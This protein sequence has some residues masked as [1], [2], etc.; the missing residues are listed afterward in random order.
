MKGVEELQQ[1]EVFR[2]MK[3]RLEEMAEKGELQGVD[4]GL[5]AIKVQMKLVERLYFAALRKTGNAEEALEILAGFEANLFGIE[6]G[7]GLKGYAVE[8][9]LLKSFGLKL[10]DAGKAIF[11]DIDIADELI[12]ELKLSDADGWN[13]A[14]LRSVSSVD[15]EGKLLEE[16]T[17]NQLVAIAAR[18]ADPELAHQAVVYCASSSANEGDCRQ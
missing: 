11:S 10:D 5:D 7:D 6:L 15:L 16:L 13:S 2:R 18:I 4:D 3:K 9:L 8:D 12:D 17:A 14:R 1:S